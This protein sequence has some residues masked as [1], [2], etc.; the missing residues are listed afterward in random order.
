MIVDLAQGQLVLHFVGCE[1]VQLSTLPF[2]LALKLPLIVIS[3]IWFP[4]D[5]R[6][7]LVAKRV[8]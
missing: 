3:Q 4:V 5:D 1:S 6:R 7:S 8:K 2:R